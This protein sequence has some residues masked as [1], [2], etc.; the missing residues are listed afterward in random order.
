MGDLVFNGYD[1]QFRRF[2]NQVDGLKMPMLTAIGNHDLDPG[3]H[4]VAASKT[5]AKFG[6]LKNSKNYQKIFGPTYYSFNVGDSYFIVMDI[7]TEFMANTV[8]QKKYFDDELVWFENELKK[9]Q[10]YKHRFVFSHVPPFKGKKQL[11]GTQKDNPEKFLRNPGYS[12]LIK[13]LCVKY[14][15]EYMFGCHLHTIDFDLWPKGKT[16]ADGDVISIITGGAGAELWQTKDFR[17]QNEYTL[18]SIQKLNPV[19]IET[20][21]PGPT[22]DPKQVKV[23]GQSI[24]YM[25]IEEPWVMTYTFIS[26][27][28]ALL[29]SCLAVVFLAFVGLAVLTLRRSRKSGA[30]RSTIEGG[31]SASG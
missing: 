19:D 23:L 15:V 6:S 26:N 24:T 7:S 20:G 29:F 17:S 16:D 13:N 21:M 5:D 11:K 9:S 31:T 10:T 12:D 30:E 14:N 3:T 22:F 27:N 28:F 18:I 4:E 2:I 8:A 25:Y 1:V